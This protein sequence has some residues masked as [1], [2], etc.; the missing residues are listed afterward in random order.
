MR[1]LL[2]T[3]LSLHLAQSVGV[4]H[5]AAKEELYYYM[6]TKDH[7]THTMLTAFMDRFY[8][9]VSKDNVEVNADL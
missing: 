6:R 1:K 8:Q 5:H 2:I 4:D 9:R 7:E 3:Y